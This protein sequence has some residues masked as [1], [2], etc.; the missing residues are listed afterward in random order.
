MEKFCGPVGG[1]QQKPPRA[2]IV[3]AIKED[4]ERAA[5]LLMDETD[6]LAHAFSLK[7]E[8]ELRSLVIRNCKNPSFCAWF[9]RRFK[10]TA[11]AEAAES[12]EVVAQEAVSSEE[13]DDNELTSEDYER[14]YQ[15]FVRGLKS[16]AKATV[17]DVRCSSVVAVGASPREAID[18]YRLLLKKDA[19]AE[20]KFAVVASTDGSNG[21]LTLASSK[22]VYNPFDG[23]STIRK[24][25][26]SLSNAGQKYITALAS[27]SKVSAHFLMCEEK[28]CG[29]HVVAS[30]DDILFCPSCSSVLT[31]PEEDRRP[32]SLINQ[33]K[34]IASGNEVEEEDDVYEESVSSQDEEDEFLPLNEDEEPV[35]EAVEPVKPAVVAASAPSNSVKTPKTEKG[36]PTTASTSR[37]KPVAK[38]Q[39]APTLTSESVASALSE[40]HKKSSEAIAANNTSLSSSCLADM[41]SLSSM[42]EKYSDDK[43]GH[44]AQLKKIH[45]ALTNHINGINKQAVEASATPK[46]P[47]QLMEDI[48][49]AS[50]ETVDEVVD[51][52]VDEAVD[53]TVDEAV[54]EEADA[55]ANIAIDFTE[56]N[57]A[58]LDEALSGNSTAASAFENLETTNISPTSVR[59]SLFRN[60]LNAAIAS[61]NAS[62]D[63]DVVFCAKTPTNSNVSWLAMLNGAPVAR[64]TASSAQR[65]ADMFEHPVFGTTTVEIAKQYGVERAL[66]DMGFE[67]LTI[68]V[69]V[70]A[71]VKGAIAQAVAS[72]YDRLQ[73]KITDEN[74]KYRDEF[75][76]AMATAA[77]GINRGFFRSVENPL[78]VNLWS[79]LSSAGIRDPQVII[80]AVFSRHADAYHK[81]LLAKA[82]DIMGR[83]PEVR[84]ELARAVLDSNY[85]AVASA[86]SFEDALANVG[87]PISSDKDK[88]V[89]T[90]SSDKEFDD[91]QIVKVVS[92]LGRR[93]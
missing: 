74:V 76:S 48:A 53:E 84:D 91:D 5:E 15:E 82:C 6:G 89:T 37:Q 24:E 55:S 63:L 16:E 13:V 57:D 80:D 3:A 40:L 88:H 52:T 93:R 39:A 66:N 67:P 49:V 19:V 54:D 4:A 68:D 29:M 58:E 20:T 12:A 73:Q 92:M 62:A 65:N 28:D 78:K 72:S 35:Y 59:I 44:R 36:M 8:K 61:D 34:A 41:D 17:G 42:I 70:R 90:A 81:V 45:I 46:S 27:D 7:E 43:P 64:A 51:E 60:A 9:K 31:D 1:K 79:V 77:I 47:V 21:F 23:E 50:D 56:V 75:M 14:G 22:I 26:E 85:S 30:S 86:S 71:N 87:T 2:L 83:S 33:I 11:A 18:A 25:Y 69:D 32:S 10:A 38:K